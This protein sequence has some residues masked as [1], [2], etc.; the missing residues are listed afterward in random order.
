[1][2]I[3]KPTS[4]SGD[5]PKAERR[6]SILSSGKQAPPCLPCSHPRWR[7]FQNPRPDQDAGLKDQV[8]QLS[9]RI[10]SLEDANA[11]RRLHQT[12]ESRLDQGMY[13]EVVDMFADDAEVVYNGGLFTGKD[14]AFV[15]CIAITSQP[16][17]TG[18]KIEPAPGFEPDPAQQ[19]DIVEV[20]QDRKSATGSIPLFHAGRDTHDLGILPL[21][22]MARLQGEGI[23]QWWEGG[24]HEVSYVKEGECLENQEA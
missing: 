8:D 14:R 10:G 2:A 22:E 18:K 19:Q 11:I 21:V 3:L 12:Y 17:R 4:E 20:A 15:A 6:A 1:M 23:L 24:I 5:S 16:A 7:V 13:E 9:N